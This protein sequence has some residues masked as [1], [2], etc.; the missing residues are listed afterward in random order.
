ML[1]VQVLENEMFKFEEQICDFEEELSISC[2]IPEECR[3][4]I[5]STVGNNN[6]LHGNPVFL[7]S[8]C[9]KPLQYTPKA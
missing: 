9:C 1:N 7:R 6:T 2:D 3:E 4:N 8:V 5:L